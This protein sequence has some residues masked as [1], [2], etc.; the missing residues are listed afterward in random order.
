MR[1]LRFCHF[2]TFYPPHNFG[3]DGITVQR[4]CQALAR[5][6]HH[7]TVVHDPAAFR[8]LNQ[9]PA[10]LV[11]P[12]TDG[13]EVV[14]LRSGLGTLP[15][16]LNHQ[17]GRPV[18][19]SRQIEKRLAL[20][21]FDVIQFHNVSLLGGPGIFRMGRAT[22]LYM[23]HD[24]WLICPTHV[25]WRHN[26]EAC[27]ERQCLRCVLH[28]HRP[29]QAWR[30][31]GA[32][33][34]ASRHLDAFIA[35]SEF[36]RAKHREFG[37]S[38][39][40]EVLPCFLPD[41]APT[42]TLATGTRPHQRP[43]FVFAGRLEALKGLQEVVALFRHYAEAD[44]LI[45]GDGDS[46]GELGGLA[47][48]CPGIRFLGRL[49][50][51]DLDRY[52]QHAIAVIVPSRGFETFGNVVI[53]AFRAGVPVIARRLGPFPEIIELARGGE[54]FSTQEELLAAVSRL[55]RDVPVRE[56]L[57]RNAYDA[58]RAH[59]TESVVV[60]RYL[61]IV[62]RAAQNHDARTGRARSASLP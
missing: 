13:V 28:H 29:P 53:E 10:P 23:A 44:L 22:K 15:L 3:G 16:L 32:L 60:P 39:E 61:E 27:P 7:V 59:W 36:S 40:M 55:Q 45:A 47:G 30:Y 58:Y 56:R 14:R 35:L 4:L 49:S 24:H 38:A 21:D 26:R 42:E 19:N 20:G 41:R 46:A 34:R 54:L 31:T 8:A 51:T 17:L 33:Q 25:L 9:G 62:R 18:V 48:E 11:E 37:F 50:F 12:E 1:P 6:G 2:T 52:Y 57:A 43:Y 5:H